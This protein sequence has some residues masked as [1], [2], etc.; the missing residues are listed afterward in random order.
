MAR[1]RVTRRRTSAPH[2]ENFLILNRGAD[3]VKLATA[4][5]RV[6]TPPPQDPS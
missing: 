6:E 2:R 4:S 1:R 5:A 3:R